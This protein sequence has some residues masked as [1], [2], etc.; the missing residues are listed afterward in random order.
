MKKQHLKTLRLTKSI[1]SNLNMQILSGGTD[2]IDITSI[3]RTVLG[4]DETAT[5]C[6]K[7]MECDSVI[8]CTAHI[9]KPPI[10]ETERCPIG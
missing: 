9:C 8:A 6:S 1:I 4:V 2:G 7:F 10:V 5:T 3:I